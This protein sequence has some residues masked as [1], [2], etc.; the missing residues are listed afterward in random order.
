MFVNVTA[1]AASEYMSVELNNLLVAKASTDYIA[2]ARIENLVAW[3]LTWWQWLQ[4]AVQEIGVTS[5]VD[6]DHRYYTFNWTTWLVTSATNDYLNLTAST[7]IIWSVRFRNNADAADLTEAQPIVDLPYV[8]LHVRTST[9]QVQLRYD[10]AGAKISFHTLW[11]G[12]RTRHHACFAVY[13]NW[14]TRQRD[15]YI[16]WTL[17]DSDTHA[18]WPST[19]Y[20]NN[21]LLWKYGLAAWYYNGDIAQVK[22]YKFTGTTFAASDA[23]RLYQWLEPIQ[24]NITSYLKRNTDEW[25]WTTAIDRRWSKN[26]THTGGVTHASSW[27]ALFK[28]TSSVLWVLATNNIVNNRN[29]KQDFKRTSEITF[30]SNAWTQYFNIVA[31]VLESTWKVSIS[32][33]II[34]ENET[35]ATVNPAFADFSSAQ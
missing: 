10:N 11:N 5:S 24:W 35:E 33:I 30:T 15:L 18:S 34:E 28:K 12:D 8:R 21:I 17:V 9:N 2:T 22:V 13:N 3:W 32:D 27:S 29:T 4:L 31:K 25:S 16:D 19:K 14:S 1:S 26:A 6:Y 7:N 23:L 20:S